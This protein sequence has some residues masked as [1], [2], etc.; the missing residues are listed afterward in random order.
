MTE[1]KAF[2]AALS[3]RSDFSIGE[4]SLQI[5]KMVAKAKELGITHL[6]LADFM[7]VSGAP[8]FVSRCNKEGIVP[9]VGVTVN[10]VGKPTEKIKDKQNNAYRLKVYPLSEKGM[11]SVFELLSKGLRPDNFYY[12]PRVGLKDV[13][14]LEDVIVTSGDVRPLWSHPTPGPLH[15]ALKTR[16]GDNY[17]VEIVGCKTILFDK[18]NRIAASHAADGK[19][20]YTRPV[21]YESADDADSTDVLRAIVTNTDVDSPWLARPYLRDMELVAPAAQEAHYSAVVGKVGDLVAERALAGTVELMDKLTYRLGKM[22]PSIPKMAP[23]EFRALVEIVRA[24]WGERFG[25]K[26]WGH[27]PDPSEMPVYKERLAFE[28]DVLKRMGFSGY[29]LLVHDIVQW[30]KANGILVGPGRGSVGGSLVA[31]LMGITDVDPIRFGLLFER[32]IN[33]DRIDLPDADLDFMSGRRH[34][35]VEYVKKKYGEEHV[36]GI[37]NFSTLGPA[38]AL[39]DSARLHKLPPFEY[40]CS[41]QM[42]KEHGVSQSLEVSADAVPDIDKFRKKYPEIWQHALRLEGAN[43][44]L[45][46]HAAGLVVS[47]VKVTDRAVVST[48]A[49]GGLPIIQWDK[50]KVEDFGLIKI[51]V[52]GLN[53]LDQIA[54]ALAYIKERH[55]KQVNMLSIPLDDPKVL[56]AFA[57]GDTVGVFQFSGG[58]MQKLLSDMAN[59]TGSLTFDDLCAATALFRP[60]PLDAGLCNEY[61]QIKQGKREPYYEHPALEK[62][63]SETYGVIVYQESVMA[64]TRELCG[65]TPGEADGVRK[66]I[67][68][69]DAEKMAEYGDKFIAGAIKSG[70]TEYQAKALWENVRGFAAYSFN[71]SHSYE[72][73]L[74]SWVTMWIKVHYPAE[75]YAAAMT[76]IDKED[77][78]ANLVKDA[79]KRNIRVLPPDINRSSSRIEIEGDDKLYAPFQAIKGISSNVSSAIVELREKAGGTFKVGVNGEIEGLSPT[80]QKLHLGRTKVNAR[81][82]DSLERVG[83][84]YSVS[85]KGVA[86]THPDR[87]RDRLELMPGFTVELVKPDRELNVSSIGK[88]KITSLI[89]EVRACEKCSLK[90]NPHP[91]PRMGSKPKFM[92]VFDSPTWQEERAGRMMEGDHADILKAAMKEA[93]INPADGYYTSL[94]KSKKPSEAK[95]L[96]NEQINGC[97]EYLKQEIDFL[98]PPVIIAL[99]SNAVRFFAPGIK[100]T[101]SDL[102]GKVLYRS[103]LDASVVM[104]I[105]L[106]Q[107][108]HD[109]SKIK[110]IESVLIQLRELL[111]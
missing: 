66:A 23:D 59:G 100:G 97:S 94:V 76:V 92:V 60:G 80:V 17:Y 58:G 78:L 2:T 12:V 102:A 48:R 89:E 47:Q 85:N 10:V 54:T 46:Q 83:A 87:L 49:E 50:S 1:E 34:E 101:P 26:V 73:T 31:Y 52:L 9:I 62:C 72:Y 16:F 81:A 22:P 35:I 30:S 68:K 103:D 63:L 111:S 84:L 74:L 105:S 43:R 20:V 70:M 64:L 5:S 45:S 91:L 67:G 86:A 25:K 36:A 99:G 32:F 104:G 106:G 13:L 19:V 41:K 3:V 51:D 109:P 53:T 95:M 40:A 98:K 96:T 4:S 39:R 38:S 93:G 110:L 108:F 7:T 65:F 90:G 88:I 42:E 82:I 8:E 18:M 21:F 75:F 29:F 27:V 6:G 14:E 55:G 44:T 57:A 11:K 33:P 61:V 28:L 15:E 77:Q 56:K 24:G 71:K 37:V 107:L 79:G 69:K